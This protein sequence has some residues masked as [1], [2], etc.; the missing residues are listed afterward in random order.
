MAAYQNMFLCYQCNILIEL[1][2]LETQILSLNMVLCQLRHL[3]QFS[4]DF[5][6]KTTFTFL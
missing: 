1:N 2:N 4:N 6:C 5:E 3:R